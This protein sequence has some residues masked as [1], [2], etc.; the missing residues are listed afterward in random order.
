MLEEPKV[1]I[2]ESFRPLST[3][4]GKWLKEAGSALMKKR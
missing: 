3:A 4:L 1:L 2:A